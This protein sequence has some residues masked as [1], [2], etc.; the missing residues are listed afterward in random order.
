MRAAWL[1]LRTA[2]TDATARRA[3]FWTQIAVMVTNDL[4]WVAFWLLFFHRVPAVNG[5]D[6]GRVILLLA[7]LTSA[8]GVVLG[9]LSN[10]R[11][12]PDLVAAG[13]L[14]EVLTL[15][16]ATLPHL[17]LRRVDPTNFGDVL[18][19]VTLFL[20]AG[21][22]TPARALTFLGGTALAALLL[23]GFL[24]ATGSLV[25]FTGRGEPGGLGL[26]AIL[27]LASYPAGIFGGPAKVVLFT[28]IPAAF[29]AAV[30]ATLIDRPD[31][32]DAL[33]LAAA[34][35]GFALLGHLLFSLGLRRYTSGSGWRLG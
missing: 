27:L 10:S 20:V 32:G 25:F 2:V 28:V 34:A 11:R 35:T 22:P 1:T 4:A 9:L 6:S 33:V 26:H 29:V 30:P 15:P 12:I 7:V 13:D 3:A 21:H 31:A 18:F 23:T 5:W 8:G 24:V 16:V 19:G 17:L 14:D